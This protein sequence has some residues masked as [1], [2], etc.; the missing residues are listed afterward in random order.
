MNDGDQL[1]ARSLLTFDDFLDSRSRES[2]L[3][4]RHVVFEVSGNLYDAVMRLLRRQRNSKVP[5]ASRQLATAVAEYIYADRWL[6]AE[7]NFD[8][9]GLFRLLNVS[10]CH[11]SI[12]T[13]LSYGNLVVVQI[14]SSQRGQMA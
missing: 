4:L 1:S 5:F 10:A 11:P 3:W 12:C 2:L 13:V 6:I 8:P 9:V 7:V 14:E